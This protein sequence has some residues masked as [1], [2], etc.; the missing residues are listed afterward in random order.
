MIK[1][2]VIG[3]LGKDAVVST[4]NGRNVINFTVAH[5]E[6]FKDAQGVQKE[7]TVWVD[8]GYWSDK[9]A[10]APYLKKGTQVYVEGAPD[11]RAYV[12]SQGQ[13]AGTITLRVSTI[14][15]LGTKPNE[16]G[17]V[18]S[19]NFGNSYAA[20]VSVPADQGHSSAPSAMDIAE[21]VDDLPF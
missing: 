21:P 8:C 16:G 2:N 6:R 5:S 1:L 13:P 14:Q 20:P 17:S 9:T 10:V 7:R 3:H 19:G 11:V 18:G 12:N 4:V 15:L